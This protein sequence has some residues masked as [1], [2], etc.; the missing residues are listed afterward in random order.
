M[1]FATDE[2][3]AVLSK[4]FAVIE[5]ISN[6]LDQLDHWLFPTKSSETA[7]KILLDV[8]TTLQDPLNI[9]TFSPEVLYNKMLSLQKMAEILKQS[10][11]DQ[12]S[13]PLVGYCDN[14]WANFFGED[15]PE[16]FYSVTPEYNYSIFDFSQYC[17][18]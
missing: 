12:I 4:S 13:W 10:S 14:I 9:S 18:Y 11:I 1:D 16:I 3:K 5:K 17:N 6:E 2:A 15:G 7:R 8:L